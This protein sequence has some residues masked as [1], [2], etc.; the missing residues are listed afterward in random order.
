MDH[1]RLKA[2]IRLSRNHVLSPDDLER[3]KP[4]LARAIA[5]ELPENLTV[6]TVMVTS[7]KEA[8]PQADLNSDA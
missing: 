8:T 1:I 7:L 4:I 6:D 5:A 3:L 2:S